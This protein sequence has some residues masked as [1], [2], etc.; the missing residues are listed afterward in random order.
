MQSPEQKK[1]RIKLNL[2]VAQTFDRVRVYST[3]LLT[4]TAAQNE[5]ALSIECAGYIFWQFLWRLLL[6]ISY[7]YFGLISVGSIIVLA[8]AANVT[9]V[10]AKA[11]ATK[12]S[13]RT[14]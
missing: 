1:V 6:P 10:A 14:F 4:K 13:P 3:I 5:V 11:T 12:Y 7:K 9:I 2:K 8:I